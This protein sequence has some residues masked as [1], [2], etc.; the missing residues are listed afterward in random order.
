M[1]PTT[2]TYFHGDLVTFR[3]KASDKSNQRGPLDAIR[4]DH[5][6]YKERK[7]ASKINL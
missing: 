5:N 6:V 3:F 4:L 1:K 7:V 2:S